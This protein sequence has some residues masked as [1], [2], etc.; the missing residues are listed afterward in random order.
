MAGDGCLDASHSLGCSRELFLSL[1]AHRALSVLPTA[2]SLEWQPP[3]LCFLF[4]SLSRVG[5]GR[6]EAN[7]MQAPFEM[8]NGEI[9]CGEQAQLW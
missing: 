6:R 7:E 1:S 5:L 4:S 2:F 9:E 8:E 3:V